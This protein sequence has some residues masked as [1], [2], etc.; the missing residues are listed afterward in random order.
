MTDSSGNGPEAAFDVDAAQALLDEVIGA[1]GA[2]AGPG[3]RDRSD[4]VTLHLPFGD[5]LTRMPG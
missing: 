4:A 2:R 3:G 1:L 5:A